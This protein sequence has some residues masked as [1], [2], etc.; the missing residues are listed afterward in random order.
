MD[1]RE[2]LK[3][4]RKKIATEAIHYQMD[5]FRFKAIEEILEE[6]RKDLNLFDPKRIT[7]YYENE[8]FKTKL[9][10][11]EKL[12]EEQFNIEF[13][14]GFNAECDFFSMYGLG[15]QISFSTHRFDSA[16]TL[17][18][19]EENGEYKKQLD[20]IEEI[21]KKDGEP[22]KEMERDAEV[23]WN[24]GILGNAEIVLKSLHEGLELD[25]K[26]VRFVKK[27]QKL[28]FYINLDF[29]VGCS[30]T[31]PKY[32]KNALSAPFEIKEL[33]AIMLHEIGHC[34]DQIYSLFKLGGDIDVL[35]D[36]TRE[37]VATGN[38]DLPHIVELFYTRNGI[39][40]KV[41]NN[42]T[43]C[44]VEIEQTIIERSNEH[45]GNS[46]HIVTNLEQ[47]ADEFSSRFGYGPYIAT[48]LSKFPNWDYE[49][50]IVIGNTLNFTTIGI[51]LIAA[52]LKAGA[53]ITTVVLSSFLFIPAVL[54]GLYYATAQL[55]AK[56]YFGYNYDNLYRRSVRIRNTTIRRLKF[57][58]E[59][60]VKDSILQQLEMLDSTIKTLKRIE[61]SRHLKKLFERIVV[62][63][64]KERQDFVIT[65]ILE[66]LNSNDVYVGYE[67]LLQYKRKNK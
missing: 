25:L 34:W 22:T 24:T 10:K 36:I 47:Q 61:E 55:F 9:T 33:V 49:N 51:G 7:K 66:D 46:K 41:S 11:I 28:K 42:P 35:Q 56:G 6:M 62:K 65:E 39:K 32:A 19:Y 17:K 14:V 40:K 21:I 20:A 12:L 18:E 54:F 3:H 4:N 43:Q 64:N 52:T 27:P 37:C 57:I 50:N 53:G 38:N 16:F 8:N 26:N 23:F 63:Y 58:K 60:F 15:R 30:E 5:N 13:I 45:I 44:M 59:P 29:I 48:G 1:L 2:A 67:K 31:V